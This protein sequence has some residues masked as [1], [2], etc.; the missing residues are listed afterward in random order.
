M[1]SSTLFQRIIRYLHKLEDSILI[2]LLL[3]MIGMAAVQILLR[4]LFSTGIFWGDGL[5]RVLVLWI[6][7]MGAMI[8]SRTNHHISIDVISRYLPESVKK[9]SDMIINLFTLVICGVMAYYSFIFV[10]NEKQ[11]GMVAFAEVPAWVCESI[12]PIAFMV[13]SFRYLVLL[14]ENMMNLRK[15]TTP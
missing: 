5:V 7:L 3:T 6:G 11:S 13:I 12:I 9:I 8:A 14:I 10:L 4:N 1:P 15:P 2:G